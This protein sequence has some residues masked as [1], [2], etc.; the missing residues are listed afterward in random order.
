MSVDE[1][2]TLNMSAISVA[3]VGGLALLAVVVIISGALR[4]RAGCCSVGY[5]E[6]PC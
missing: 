5:A 6:G 2:P 4:R 1:R 3:G